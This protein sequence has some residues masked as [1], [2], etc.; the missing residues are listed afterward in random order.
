M[1]PQNMN[2]DPC[3]LIKPE[4]RFLFPARV[5]ANWVRGHFWYVAAAAILV[6]ESRKFCWK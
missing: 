3:R 2:H 4:L 5:S 1:W 6:R